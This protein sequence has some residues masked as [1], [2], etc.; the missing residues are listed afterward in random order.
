LESNS[1]KARDAIWTYLKE[2]LEKEES[3]VGGNG[4][5]LD[6]REEIILSPDQLYPIELSH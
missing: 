1:F 5:L 4:S 3:V 6:V 2:S